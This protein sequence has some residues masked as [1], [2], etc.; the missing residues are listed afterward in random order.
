MI[1]SPVRGEDEA[2]IENIFVFKGCIRLV[3]T[4]FGIADSTGVVRIE[5][6]DILVFRCCCT[7]HDSQTEN[8]ED[9][10]NEDSP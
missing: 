9:E 6:V 10:C 5:A 3:L 2:V 4:S 7:E 1:G 8:D